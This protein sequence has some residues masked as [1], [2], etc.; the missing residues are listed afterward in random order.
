MDS[1][2]VEGPVSTAY[3]TYRQLGHVG[4]DGAGFFAF[5]EELGDVAATIRLVRLV[6]GWRVET[7]QHPH[8]LPAAALARPRWSDSL[9]AVIEQLARD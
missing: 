7:Q 3:V 2:A 9:R 4:S 1:V 5:D 6:D 8:L